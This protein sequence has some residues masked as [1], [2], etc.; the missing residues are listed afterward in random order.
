MEFPGIPHTEETHWGAGEHRRKG[1]EDKEAE[2]LVAA[3]HHD[4]KE[5]VEELAEVNTRCP[6]ITR[7]YSLKWKHLSEDFF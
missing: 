2:D 5:L 1:A 3:E 7:I 6:N 4:N